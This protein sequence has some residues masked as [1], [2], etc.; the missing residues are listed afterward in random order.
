MKGTVRIHKCYVMEAERLLGLK[1]RE[2][3]SSDIIN[4]ISSLM[5]S[6]VKDFVE[7]YENRISPEAYFYADY[8]DGLETIPFTFNVN[9]TSHC[10]KI[11]SFA[12]T[13]FKALAESEAESSE[14][15]VSKPIKIS[16]KF[17][18]VIRTLLALG[19]FKSYADKLRKALTFSFLTM[20]PLPD[21][22][23]LAKQAVIKVM[24]N[25]CQARVAAVIEEVV[26]ATLE[27]EKYNI[28]SIYETCMGMGGVFL[29][30]KGHI[31]GEIP[32]TINDIDPN[33]YT[34][35]KCIQNC[36]K[37]L[38]DGVNS[39]QQEL[40]MKQPEVLFQE[41]QQELSARNRNIRS[42][43]KNC[44]LA[45]R[46]IYLNRYC[47][48]NREGNF[49]K[50]KTPEAIHEDLQRV[51]AII[52]KFSERLQGVA[53]TKYDLLSIIATHQKDKELLL[54]IDP[55]Y[56]STAG[57]DNKSNGMKGF[58]VNDHRIL[59]ERLRQFKGKFILCCR[60]TR[61]RGSGSHAKHLANIQSGAYN[62]EDSLIK[63]FFMDEFGRKAKKA[64]KQFYYKEIILN[65]VGH[66]E[67]LIT[68]YRLRDFTP[69]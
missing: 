54:F 65:K 55:P 53:I 42:V 68:N 40:E 14:E 31:T 34:L 2:L 9:P 11:I 41:I 61:S 46:Y 29:N 47:V 30:V 44:R 27:K 26:R 62:V 24:G 69:F 21:Y 63:G 16:A 5:E 7:N 38:C 19:L 58:T 22:V 32:Y 66:K 8:K 4:V 25:K 64:K 52:M 1:K 3:K 45:S 50:H 49:D 17:S 33:K 39:L 10:G 59:C 13:E 51:K 12:M 35:Y 67:V 20:S 37:Q 18:F 56:I 15:N 48:R 43:K 6:D 36:P 28:K 57:Y 23:R 60:F